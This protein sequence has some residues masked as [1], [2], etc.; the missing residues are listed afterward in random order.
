MNWYPPLPKETSGPPNLGTP[1][2]FLSWVYSQQ[3]RTL[4]I[5]M[6]LSAMSMAF[7]AAVPTLIGTA[8]DAVAAGTS[9]A[10]VW[11]AGGAVC[12]LVMA[13]GSFVREFTATYNRLAARFCVVDLISE[14]VAREDGSIGSGSG[15]GVTSVDVDADNIG[16]GCDTLTGIP[17]A[18]LALAF[19]SWMLFT[20]DPLLLG[21]L[22][23]A[24]AFQAVALGPLL[25]PTERRLQRYRALQGSLNAK[26]NDILSGLRI[27]R[28]IGGEGI[29]HQKYE[30]QSADLQRAGYTV[31]AAQSLVGGTAVMATGLL[32]V[33]ATWIAAR[34]AALGE[35][36]VGT[37]VSVFGYAAFLWIPL[38][39]LSRVGIGLTTAYAAARRV[40]GALGTGTHTAEARA[41]RV[42][43]V[44]PG[45]LTVVADLGD[46][47]TKELKDERGDEVRTVSHEMVLFS[48]LL[49]EVV[50]P[51]GR[52]DDAR[53]LQVLETVSAQDILD[54]VGGLDGRVEHDGLNLSGGQR[55]RLLL[56][57]GL[58]EESETFVAIEPTSALDPF[59]E[60]RVVDGTTRYRQGRTTVV[61]SS[62]RA[63]AAVAPSTG[64]HEGAEA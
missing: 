50:D 2:R 21:V 40:V 30:E 51:H 36:S 33:A 29:F 28:G 61:A 20:I 43:D 23:A 35:I 34:Q 4:A 54:S 47:A 48:G 45:E 55:H 27:I 5:A 22:A 1:G 18:L 64:G 8:V 56:A 13:A 53:I 9:S 26:I 52:H 37:L 62:S 49:R 14:R 6:G 19:V 60:M 42:P 12:A 57:R 15:E 58:L 17:G 46:I 38:E 31:A 44:P 7:F 24:V 16:R 25:K 41:G 3:R 59:T 10:A 39:T 32:V 11:L 63:W